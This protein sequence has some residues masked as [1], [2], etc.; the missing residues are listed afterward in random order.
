[1]MK[2]AEDAIQFLEAVNVKA[3]ELE[4]KVMGLMDDDTDP[5]TFS[6]AVLKIA[7]YSY[8]AASIGQAYHVMGG[9]PPSIEAVKEFTHIMRDSVM[10]NYMAGI[11]H[12][13]VTLGIVDPPKD[14]DPGIIVPKLIIPGGHRH[15]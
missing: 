9:K 2:D 11:E 8:G 1:M 4:A 14:A 6:L 7:G 3:N 12:A 5:I 13:R 15:G 10:A